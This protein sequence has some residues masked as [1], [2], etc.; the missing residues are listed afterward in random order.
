M[1]DPKELDKFG[2]LL[3]QDFLEKNIPLNEGLKKIASENGLNKQQLQRVAE[4]ANV[5]TYLNL[6]KKSKN[7]YLKFDVADAGHVHEQL[8]KKGSAEEIDI[9][10]K[11]EYII[12]TPDLDVKD[13]FK[14]YKKAE[15]ISISDEDLKN[16][17]GYRDNTKLA[18]FTRKSSYLEGVVNY[19]DHNFIDAQG[20]FVS[21]I[22]DMEKL[23]KQEIL[24]GTSFSD[25]TNVIKT[26]AVCTGEALCEYLENRLSKNIPHIDFHKEAMYSEVLINPESN[27]YKLATLIDDDFLYALKLESA[28]DNYID[29]YEKLRKEFDAPNVIKHAG[30]FNTAS[31]SFKWFKEHPKTTAA[32]LLVVSYKLGRASQKNKEEKK[33]P[34]TREAVNLRLKEYKNK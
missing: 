22:E 1:I 2:E 5:N 4:S 12:D 15:N 25:I 7:R 3:S 24:G 18:E 6:I 32:M 9:E 23:V 20:S 10:D 26:A 13:I 30:F 19:L 28:Y 17:L 8:L 33:M 31:E 16:L 29:Q 14:L 34:L 21:R 27:I 11:E